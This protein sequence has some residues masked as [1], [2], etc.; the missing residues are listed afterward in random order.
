VDYKTTKLGATHYRLRNYI[1]DTASLENEARSKEIY[2]FVESFSSVWST[3]TRM[4]LTGLTT[5][6]FNYS[7]FV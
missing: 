2:T 7:Q 6:F 3:A 4:F 1:M 5:Q